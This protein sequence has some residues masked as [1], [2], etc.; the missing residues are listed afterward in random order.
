MNNLVSCKYELCYIDGGSDY[1]HIGAK[2][3]SEIVKILDD[4]TEIKGDV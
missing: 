4:E 2:D 3:F 1:A